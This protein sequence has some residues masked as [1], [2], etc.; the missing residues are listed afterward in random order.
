MSKK[1]LSLQMAIFLQAAVI[2]YTL[3]GVC[4]R[5]AGN[6]Q[7]LSLG[8]ILWFGCEFLILGVYAILWQQI[9]KRVD[10]SV[11]YVN[12]SLALIW[13]LLW[14]FLIFREEIRL[15][16]IIGVIIIVIGTLIVNSDNA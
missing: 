14:A 12:R 15:S 8:F 3:A 1:K 9:I 7:F 6:H 4:G 11:A 10:L 13:S 16:N 5:F 2:I